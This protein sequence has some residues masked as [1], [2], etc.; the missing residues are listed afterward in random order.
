MS[1]SIELEVHELEVASE[2]PYSFLSIFAWPAALPVGM[3]R[4]HGSSTGKCEGKQAARRGTRRRAGHGTDH[5]WAEEQ[6]LK[7]SIILC[8]WA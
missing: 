7:R 5:G 8:W 3:L 2:S 1:W 6:G 4:I